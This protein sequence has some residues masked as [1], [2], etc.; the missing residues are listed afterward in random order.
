MD[1]KIRH[2]PPAL[3]VAVCFQMSASVQWV[4]VWFGCVLPPT[5]NENKKIQK[6]KKKERK[7]VGKEMKNE[8]KHAPFT[9]FFLI[10]I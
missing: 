8:P 10:F 5:E 2:F 6:K 1:W 9:L 3:T 7:A 4:L